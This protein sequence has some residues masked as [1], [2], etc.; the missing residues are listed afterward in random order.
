M[1][2]FIWFLDSNLSR[3]AMTDSLIYIVPTLYWHLHKPI[4]NTH[5][6]THSH[7]HNLYYLHSKWLKSARAFAHTHIRTY[8]HRYCLLPFSINGI[9]HFYYSNL[10]RLPTINVFTSVCTCKIYCLWTLVGKCHWKWKWKKIKWFDLGYL[11]HNVHSIRK[12]RNAATRSLR[13]VQLHFV[14]FFFATKIWYENGV[15]WEIYRMMLK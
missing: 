2:I 8:Q 13:Q 7:S 11:W 15:F 5:S 6:L 1:Y 3:F 4:L 12:I 9:N 10:N 14:L